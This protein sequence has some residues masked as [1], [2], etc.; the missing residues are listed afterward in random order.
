MKKSIGQIALTEVGYLISP[1]ERFDEK[2]YISQV[3]NEVGFTIEVDKLNVDFKHLKNAIKEV[4]II[5]KDIDELED[6]DGIIKKV[7]ELNK[8]LQPAIKE[9]NK[10]MPSLQKAVEELTDLAKE[11]KPLLKELPRRIVDYFV[12]IYVQEFHPKLF[13]V[14]NINGVIEEVNDQ[15]DFAVK[16]IQWKRLPRLIS[17][18]HKNF[19]E[20]YDWNGNFNGEE[21]IGRLSNLLPSFQVAGDIY[22]QD[23]S[24]STQLGFSEEDE[25]QELRLP[26]FEDGFSDETYTGVNFHLTYLPRVLE[27]LVDI[28]HLRNFEEQGEEFDPEDFVH[29]IEPD[30]Y[31]VKRRAGL[32]FYPFAYGGLDYS[33]QLSETWL[34]EINGNLDLGAGFGLEVRPDEKINIKTDLFSDKFKEIINSSFEAKLT[35]SEPEAEYISIHG[36]PEEKGYFVGYKDY[37]LRFS[38]GGKN[39]NY[40]LQTETGLTGFTFRIDGTKG[41]GFIQKILKKVKL[42]SVTNLTLGYSNDQG[43]YFAGSSGLE[44]FIPI[45]KKI[46]PVFLE[47]SF[48]GVYVSDGIDF[49]FETSFSTKLGPVH[50]NIEKIGVQYP[51]SFPDKKDGNFG[52]VDAGEIKFVAPNY[53]ALEVESEIITGGGFLEFD[54]EN[55]RYSG[56]LSLNMK[57]IELLAIG[58][59]TTKLPNNKKGFSMLISINMLFKDPIQLSFGFTLKGVGGIVG[60]NRTMKVEEIRKRLATGA[61][62]SIMFPD[63]PIK[64][65]AKII[66]DLR[67][68][69]PPKEK[70]FII[71]PFL[72]IGW[73]V[74]KLIELDLGVIL[75]FPFSGRLILIGSLGIYI[76]DKKIAL[77]EIHV[78]VLGDFNFA[79]DYIRIEGKIRDSHVVGLPLKGGFA[80]VLAWDKRPQFLLSVGGYHPKYKKPPKFPAID[81]LST[82]IKYGSMV[83]L[84]CAY[85]TAI[86]SNSFQV[87][88]EANLLAKAGKASLSGHFGFN[89]LIQFNPI[90]F[91]AETSLRVALKYGSRKLAGV[92]LYFLL[93]G[94]KPWRVKGRAKIKIAFIKISI[95]FNFKWGGKQEKL[96]PTYITEIQMLEDLG[97]QIEAAE[98]WGAKLP[99]NFTASETLRTIEDSEKAGLVLVHPSGYLELRQNLIPFHTNMEKYGESI[100]KEKTSFR[101]NKMSISNGTTNTNI[102]ITNHLKEFHAVSQFRSLSDAQKISSPDFEEFRSGVIFEGLD[103][104]SFHGSELQHTDSLYEEINMDENSANNSNLRS[105]TEPV[106]NWE[107]NR[108]HIRNKIRKQDQSNA[109]KLL[110][111]APSLEEEC[112]VILNRFVWEIHSDLEFESYTKAIDYIQD[113]LD[114]DHR[115]WQIL[116]KSAHNLELV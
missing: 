91:E 20:V 74:G 75:E 2:E 43:I 97:K 62:N 21:F 48:I 57:S 110:E 95:K 100:F 55:G 65:S 28:D 34:L 92:D 70:H 8:R 101:I 7:K 30:E 24:I 35:K 93:S 102:P 15:T 73:G 114:D 50:T 116:E 32:F 38:V 16:T 115:T 36:N 56:M 6:I 109:F 49:N 88:F 104:F 14:L 89:A 9:I 87:G 37:G 94:P 4:K 58:L 53:V 81:R 63:D 85:Y 79:E 51:F 41:D 1:F 26:L 69:F 47:K 42:E 72:R 18:P 22:D 5:L 82:S 64:N 59:I 71:A 108:F 27:I 54:K 33:K 105:L 84:T 3:L 31:E 112:Y 39:G 76:P 60:I 66:S 23:T 13:S 99:K 77:T 44:I 29:E 98:N 107:E 25:V 45:H 40:Y 103:D 106:D 68:I 86:T 61:I 11:L 46:G 113:N 19:D 78:D 111:E 96:P 52:P 80:F 83:E 10:A 90:Y 17:K 12:Y 67:A